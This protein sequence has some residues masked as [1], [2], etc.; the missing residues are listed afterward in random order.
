LE[1]HLIASA[2]I[3]RLETLHQ[4]LLARGYFDGMVFQHGYLNLLKTVSHA[5]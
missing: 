4:L 2:P 5:I 1:H 3:Y